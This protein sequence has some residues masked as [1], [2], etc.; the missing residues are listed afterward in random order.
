MV[1]LGNIA[2]CEGCFAVAD[3]NGKLGTFL[4]STD[5][6]SLISESFLYSQLKDMVGGLRGT[7]I[8]YKL[9]SELTGQCVVFQDGIL[10]RDK[11][12]HPL[13]FD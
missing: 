11:R 6:I 7:L 12:S 13:I 9:Q 5:S 2:R 10:K 4:T 1:I 3:T 8:G